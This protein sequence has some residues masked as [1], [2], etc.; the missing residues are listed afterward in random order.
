AAVT[1]A[2]ASLDH[3]ISHSTRS[4]SEYVYNNTWVYVLSTGILTTHAEWREYWGYNAMSPT[5]VDGRGRRTAVVTLAGGTTYGA[6]RAMNLVA[7]RALDNSGSGTISRTVVGI[8][9]VVS[10]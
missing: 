2:P 8:N 5:N 3:Q 6:A 7:V 10:D 9:W 4:G 1:Q